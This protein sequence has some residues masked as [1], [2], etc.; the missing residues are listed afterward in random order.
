MEWTGVLMGL[1]AMKAPV[2]PRRSP[3]STEAPGTESM[4]PGICRAAE[5]PSFPN[6]GPS[7]NDEPISNCSGADQF[8]TTCRSSPGFRRGRV[9]LAGNAARIKSAAG[10]QV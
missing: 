8:R 5:D 6:S 10:G 3:R 2:D 7:R 9:P 4:A 1:R